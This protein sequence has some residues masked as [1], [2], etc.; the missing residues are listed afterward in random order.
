MLSFTVLLLSK[1][2][3]TPFYRSWCCIINSTKAFNHFSSSQ[4][5]QGF[6]GRELFAYVFICHY[7]VI[8]V[9][10]FM[11]LSFAVHTSYAAKCFIIL[12]SF[13][14][15]DAVVSW[16]PRNHFSSGQVKQGFIGGKGII[17][18]FCCF[19]CFYHNARF[20]Q[21]FYEQSNAFDYS[22]IVNW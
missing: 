6:I 20:H 12:L 1:W 8:K 10:N 2:C 13:Y 17:C 9:T 18:F 7:K 19:T 21:G 5:N 4:I 11:V 14:R 22:G 16:T 15:P 3:M